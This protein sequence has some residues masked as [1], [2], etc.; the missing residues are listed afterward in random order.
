M[1]DATSTDW[2]ERWI[3]SISAAP[4]CAAG[5]GAIAIGLLAAFGVARSLLPATAPDAAA[6]AAPPD[7]PPATGAPLLAGL[8]RLRRRLARELPRSFRFELPLVLI[9]VFLGAA[10]GSA[11]ALGLDP[12]SG[13][14]LPARSQVL[15]IGWVALAIAALLWIWTLRFGDGLADLGFTARRLGATLLGAVAFYVAWIPVQG[16]AMA[17]ESGVCELLRRAP[18]EQ[19]LV[20]ALAS[21]PAL[22]RDPWVVACLAVAGP[23]YEEMVFRGLLLRGLL[24]VAPAGVAIA[25]DAALF[26]AF[27]NGGFS[28]VFV[29]G[30][31]LAWLMAR[32]RSIAAPICFHVVHNGLTLLLI[33]HSPG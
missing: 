11:A 33:A 12:K 19:S 23:V 15:Q 22:L 13:A 14:P 5:A 24:A 4:R 7:P 10:L 2:I 16:G 8:L 29:L 28:S 26:C 3:S 6:P 21:Q 25:L 32:T 30:V 31:A 18:Q 17:L 1:T 20:L 27:H 9:V